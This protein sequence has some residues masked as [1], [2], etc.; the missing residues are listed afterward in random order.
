MNRFPLKWRSDCKQ[1]TVIISK[2]CLLKMTEMA[3]EH[4]P[5]E[6]GT[7]LVGCY[8]DDGFKASALDLAL[9]SSDSKGSRTSF[10]RGIA[11]LQGFYKKLRKIFSGKRYYVGEWHSHPDAAPIPSY[12]DNRNQLEIAKD[13]ITNCPECILIIIGGS[14]S[15]FDEMGVFV[16]SQKRGR[17]ILHHTDK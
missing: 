10:Y 14:L 6:V 1:Y 7:S 15:N 5:N 13:T 16:Y 11:G 12:T 17:V 9:L 8:S 4:Y 2:S 3:Q